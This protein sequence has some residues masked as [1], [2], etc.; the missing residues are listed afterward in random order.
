MM[1]SLEIPELQMRPVAL[2]PRE[3]RG[4][5]GNPERPGRVCLGGPFWTLLPDDYPDEDAQTKA[6]REDPNWRWVLGVL[7]L[8]LNIEEGIPER[9]DRA[10][11]T[12]KLVRPDGAEPAAIAWS[13]KPDRLSSP[14]TRSTKVS[15]GPKLTIADAGIDASVERGTERIIQDVSLDALNEKTPEPE[16]R[17]RRTDSA[18]LEGCARFALIVRA[19][20]IADVEARLDIG[21]VTARRRAVFFWPSTAHQEPQRVTKLP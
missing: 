5:G 15:L 4:E 12:V 17:L 14:V 3:V 21:Y 7:A 16:W 8:S 11:L 20:V 13:I 1:L 18:E 6:F 2:E 9:Y 10:W 19:P